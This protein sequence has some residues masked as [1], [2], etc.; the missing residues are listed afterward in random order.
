[1]IMKKQ[2]SFRELRTVFLWALFALAVLAPFERGAAEESSP[3]AGFLRPD[4]ENP[5]KEGDNLP[6]WSSVTFFNSLSIASAVLSEYS[7]S[8]GIAYTISL[9]PKSCP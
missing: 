2:H 5:L 1:M 9:T 6:E 4:F 7:F 3:Q 8:G